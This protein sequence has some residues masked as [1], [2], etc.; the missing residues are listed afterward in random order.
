MPGRY[1]PGRRVILAQYPQNNV[2]RIKTNM[3]RDMEHYL[4]MHCSP[5]L[6]SLKAANMFRFVYT[7]AEELDA[8]VTEW[9][10]RLSGKGVKICVLHKMDHAALLYVYREKLLKRDLERDGVALFMEQYQYPKGTVDDAIRHLKKRFEESD[11]FPHEIGLFLGYPLGDVKG[12]IKNKGRHCLCC[13]YWKV[14]CNACETM[15]LFEK[16]S[17]CRDVYKHLFE[18]GTSVMQLT[19]AA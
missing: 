5:T 1:M 17:K 16:F 18:N 6:A 8:Y 10:Q 14:Y 15:R 2:R 7:A 19:V 11:A 13:G 9:N 3:E 4:I 12:F